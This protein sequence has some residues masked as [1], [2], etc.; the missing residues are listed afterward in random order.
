MIKEF[1]P[2]THTYTIDGK[3]VPSVTDILFPVT[4]KG[5][6]QVP[7]AML[8][9]KA[10]L[11]TLAHE[12]C[13]EIDYGCF[14]GECEPDVVGY[15]EGYQAFLRD[16]K[17]RWEFIEHPIYSANLGYA[18]TLDRAGILDGKFTVCDLKTYASMGRAQKI[19]LCAQANGYGIALNEEYSV[20]PEQYI[21]VLLKPTGTYTVYYAQEIER[22][23]QF[24]AFELFINLLNLKKLVEG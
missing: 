11:G 10:A 6:L 23:L 22:K 9:Y 19:A 15:L 12:Y 7:P 14:D 16:Y 13:A 5:L 8:Q 2:D 3:I 4:G 20:M 17:P 1:D 21:G 24:N 18:G